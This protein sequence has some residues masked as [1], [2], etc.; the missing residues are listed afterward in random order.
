MKTFVLILLCLV[1]IVAILWLVGPRVPVDNRLTFDASTLPDDLDTWLAQREASVAGIRPGVAKEIVW[2]DPATRS[3]TQLAIVYIHGF[4]ATSGEIRP[5]P[6]RLAAAFGANLFFTRL[7][8]HG[9]DGPAMAEPSVNDWINDYAEAIAIGRSIGER[10]IVMAT[11]TGAALASWAAT[12]PALSD[13]VAGYVLV[14]PNYGIQ[15]SGSWLLTGPWGGLLARL[16]IGPERGFEPSSEDHGRL[17]TAR[18]P[19]EALLPMAALTELARNA[20]LD[21]AASPAL[22]IY[23]S[24]DKVVRPELSAEAARQWGAGSETM[25][26]EGSDD[27]R[28]HVIAGDALSPSTTGLVAGRAE[29]WIRS[30]GL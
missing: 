3:K 8:G 20:P 19:T 4:S 11:S 18:Y 15:G 25:I 5:V 27:P 1:A 30:L 28:S 17:W 24:A 9:R 2:A 14:S 6:D 29:T 7:A 13:G 12:Q 22:F 10:V 26:V 16:V 23:S 21:K